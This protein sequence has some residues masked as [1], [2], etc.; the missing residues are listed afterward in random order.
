MLNNRR[1]KIIII[2]L[3]LLFPVIVFIILNNDGDSASAVLSYIEEEYD[4]KL[5]VQEKNEDVCQK[6]I[7]YGVDAINN[8]AI[9]EWEKDNYELA[10]SIGK[11]AYSRAL[12][13]KNQIEFAN[14]LN[15]LG[16]IYWRLGNNKDA[17]EA[18]T[19]SAK[20]ANE[21]NLYKLLGL[22]YTNQA[23]ILKEQKQYNKALLF[24]QQ[25]IDIF[26]K[27]NFYRELGIAYN[28]YGQ[29]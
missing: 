13:E 20:L 18:Y 1:I 26:K 8:L 24:S 2:G 7:N 22:T 19:E 27:N 9:S 14:T 3:F 5:K 17:M 4:T 16:L 15:I 6:Y 29:I 28:N 12:L 23:L 21:L 10:L 11:C 25:A